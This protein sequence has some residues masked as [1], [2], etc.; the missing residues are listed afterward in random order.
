MNPKVKGVI[1]AVAFDDAENADAK[2]SFLYLRCL[3][4][5]VFNLCDM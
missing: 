4:V 5:F 3:F 2:G 1:Y